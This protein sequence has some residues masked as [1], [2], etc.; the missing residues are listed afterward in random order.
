MADTTN[1]VS[2]ADVLE[3]TTLDVDAVNDTLDEW[4]A[5][6]VEVNGSNVRDE[7][8]DTFALGPMRAI[9]VAKTSDSTSSFGGDTT[10]KWRGW[11]G[12]GDRKAPIQEPGVSSTW[13]RVNMQRPGL[14]A[15]GGVSA[16]GGL[17]GYVSVGFPLYA[18]DGT[19]G[20]FRGNAS[21]EY[22]RWVVFCSCE[23]M[24]QRP[25]NE[26]PQLELALGFSF[27]PSAP[28]SEWNILPNTRR[29][30]GIGNAPESIAGGGRDS[31]PTSLS[32][33]AVTKF[34]PELSAGTAS[35][36]DADG[37]GKA[38]VYISLFGRYV[39]GRHWGQGHLDR[40]WWSAMNVNLFATNYR[41]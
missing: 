20:N 40:Y 15:G 1:H 35:A 24:I 27:D 23:V 11:L 21:N 7:A 29:G 36:A 28:S 37:D 9:Y 2:V 12:N 33:T 38:T 6:T 3:N 31:V 19:L 41:R 18:M 30:F 13:V 32:Y 34:A 10:V 22:N 17:T 16:I 4:E 8:L 25:R 39:N 14:T 5:K 26:S